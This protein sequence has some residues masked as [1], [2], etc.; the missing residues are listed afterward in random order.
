LFIADTKSIVWTHTLCRTQVDKTD[1]TECSTRHWSQRNHSETWALWFPIKSPSLQW[2]AVRFTLKSAVVS[3]LLSYSLLTAWLHS[4]KS[5]GYFIIY[6][7]II[8]QFFL[9]CYTTTDS[10]WSFWLKS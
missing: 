3:Y 5:Y 1:N 7:L 6:L 4:Y 8:A 2:R 10:V 9:D